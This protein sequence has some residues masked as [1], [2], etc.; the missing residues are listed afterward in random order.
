M[1]KKVREPSNGKRVGGNIAAKF[2]DCPEK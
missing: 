2:T 1:P